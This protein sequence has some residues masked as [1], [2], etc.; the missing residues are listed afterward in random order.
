MRSLASFLTFL[1]LLAAE[2]PVVIPPPQ[3]QTL[4]S[5]KQFAAAHLD[6]REERYCA[7]VSDPINS[8]TITIE[9]LDT[10]EHHRGT[11]STINTGSLFDNVFAQS[12]GTDF[13]FDHWTTL[14]S[15]RMA[16]YRFSNRFNS[17][18]HAGWIWADENT[19]AIARMMFRSAG[20]TAHLF[21]SAQ[22][23]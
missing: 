15:K 19:G 4:D 20:T 16:V 14:K 23:R 13:E 12:A 8:K 6:P 7:Q 9:L 1:P 3:A 5:I 18:T 22:T 11:P 17:Q 21:C 10:T 2:S